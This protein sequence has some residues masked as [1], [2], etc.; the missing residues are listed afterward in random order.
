MDFSK[1]LFRAHMVGKIIDVPKPLTANQ[2]LMFSDYMSRS[3]GAGRPLTENQ[4]KELISLTYK[5]NESK[6][7]TLS[8]STKKILSTL[9]YAEKTKRKI[10]IN[11]PKIFKGLSVEKEA[12]DILTRVSGLFL[13]V[14]TERKQN[15]WVTGIVDVEPQGVVIDIKSSWSWESFSTILQEKPNEIYLRQGDS[16]MDLWH[17]PE[18]L[19]CH[20]LVDTP[21]K[22]VEGEIKR[23]DY[24]NDILDFEGNV[25]EE[26]IHD[27]K[28]IVSNHI[29]SRKGIEKFCS[30][31]SNIH[32]EWFDDFIE[33]PENERVHMIPHS[34]DKVRIEQR[35]EC[36]KLAREHMNNCKPINNFNLN[37]L[38]N[39]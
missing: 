8:D 34:Y 7:Y 2:Q 39:V 12:R 17:I 3:G 10:D 33:I 30:E 4:Q 6:K 29:F 24:N 18:F 22:L 25:R 27:V 32:I 14:N 26:S 35:N 31:S 37:L 9:A 16:Y 5:F 20:I 19:L 15:E 21:S 13:T 11:S 36:I 1:Y 28:R 23:F 38:T